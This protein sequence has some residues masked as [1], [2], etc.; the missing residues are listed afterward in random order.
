MGKEGEAIRNFEFACGRLL[1]GRGKLDRRVKSGRWCPEILR[2][3]G[4]GAKVHGPVSMGVHL[5]SRGSF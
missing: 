1:T 3:R 4:N 5:A 2:R